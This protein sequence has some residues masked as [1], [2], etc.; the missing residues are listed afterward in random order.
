LIDQRLRSRLF[1]NVGLTLTKRRS[2]LGYLPPLGLNIRESQNENGVC[3][4][5]DRAGKPQES[6]SMLLMMINE[7]PT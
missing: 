1:T 3:G 2:A 5:I 6:V 7:I 4:L